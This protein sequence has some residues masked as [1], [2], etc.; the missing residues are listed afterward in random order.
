MVFTD[1]IELSVYEMPLAERDICLEN[2]EK[3]I[4][5]KKKMLLEKRKMLNDALKQNEYLEGVK[6]DY[7]VYYNFIIQQKT[8]EL[9]AMETLH[10]YTQDI[11]MNTNTTEEEIKRIKIEQNKILVEMRKIKKRFIFIY[12]VRKFLIF[13]NGIFV[14]TNFFI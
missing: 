1:E 8:E 11:I 5:D 12:Q 7:L 4:K 6:N 3:Q 13:S 14:E 9:K 2:M 10:Q